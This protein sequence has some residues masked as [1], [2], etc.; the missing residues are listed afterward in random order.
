VNYF[1]DSSALIKLYHPE[2]G[3]QRVAAMFDGP[4]RRII[5]SRLTGVELHSALALKTRTGHLDRERSAALRIRFLNDVASGAIALVAVSEFHYPA[6]ERL[7]IRYG[8]GQGL[9]TLDA[10][11]LAVALEVQDLV[12]VEALV[13]ADK[14]LCEVA[15][16]EGFAVINPERP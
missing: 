11:Q 5:I 3:S 1:F 15:T 13:A 8:E 12:G 9:R 16:L 7:I 2:L 6:A 14:I 4:D 10:L